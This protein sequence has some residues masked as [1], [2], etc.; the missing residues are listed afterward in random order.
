LPYLVAVAAAVTLGSLIGLAGQPMIAFLAGLVVI[1]ALLALVTDRLPAVSF[2][3]V[4]ILTLALPDVFVNLGLETAWVLLVAAAVA[5]LILYLPRARRPLGADIAVGLLALG[6]TI[7][8]LVSSNAVV[9]VANAILFIGVYLAA[10]LG[11][12]SQRLVVITVGGIGAL[13]AV[14]AI[15]EWL[16]MTSSLVPFS[17]HIDGIP[18]DSDRS[19]GLLNNPNGFGLLEAMVICFLLWLGPTRRTAPVIALCAIGLLMSGS[20]EAMF[21]LLIATTLL[22]LR[23]PGRTAAALAAVAVIAAVFVAVVPGAA[24]RFDPRGFRSDTA[25]LE[26]LE[27]WQNALTLI[28]R[29]PIYGYGT[30]LTELIVDQAYL[31]WLVTGGV[32]GAT[33]AIAGLIA[34]ALAMRP[35]PVAV[36]AAS[37]GFLASVFSGTTLSFVLLLAG[38]LPREELLPDAGRPAAAPARG[39]LGRAP[40]PTG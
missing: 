17:P 28:E 34:L 2:V 29:S 21:G 1:V 8:A 11:T 26:R 16:P 15:A 30:E 9:V 4:A 25:L 27:L 22:L 35:W 3:T 20:R 7:P 23:A 38:A 14:V 12:P 33:L 39:R 10:R 36:L 40:P 5:P 37:A 32:L 13:H 19:T 31:R 18:Y 24:D 6:A